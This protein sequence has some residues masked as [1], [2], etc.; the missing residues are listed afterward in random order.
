M[1]VRTPLT[2]PNPLGSQYDDLLLPAHTHVVRMQTP[3]AIADPHAAIA[4]ALAHPIGCESLASIA[5]ARYDSSKKEHP[6]ATIVVSDNTRPV[7]YKG[8][9]GI[10][11]PIIDTIMGQ[12]YRPCDILVLIATGTH[13]AMS[14]AEIQKIL[15]ERVFQLGIRVVN[16]DC[17]DDSTL[18]DLGNT[19]RGTRIFIDSAYVQADLKIA[20]GLVESHFM[21]G[22][23]GGRKAICPGIIGEASTFVFHGAQLMADPASRDLNISGNPVHEESL[24]VAKRAGVDF[25]VNVTLD[26]HFHITGIFCGDL[27]QAH[28]AAVALIRS[29]VGVHVPHAADIVVTHG[30]FVGI[31]HYQCAKCAVGSLGILKEGGYL[32]IIADTT[33]AANVVGALT[34]R[35]MLSLL[36]LVGPEAF[37]KE[38]CSDDWT[39]IPDQW[40]VQQWAKVFD[41]IPMD[42][43][44]LYSPKLDS[45][46]WPALPGIDG[47][48]FLDTQ[49][50]QHPTREC[51][52]QVVGQALS[53]IEKQSGKSLQDMKIAYVSEGPYVIPTTDEP[54][55]RTER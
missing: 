22:A 32:V 47:R 4:D 11:M 21:A 54:T 3:Q 14:D 31:N 27:E 30:G 43:L 50:Q 5:K 46:W 52:Q 49:Q 55:R 20:T 29:A 6:T 13:R 26:H 44:I 18:T 10:L 28:L 41:R 34:Y 7:P 12:G 9:E 23:S 16:H 25:L 45:F 19:A 36:K 35:T 48:Q 33:D 17:R 15:D 51:F 2:V 38:I 37:L 42:H 24:E 40:Q 39:F 1:D 8:E 53:Y